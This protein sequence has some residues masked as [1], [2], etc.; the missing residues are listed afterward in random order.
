M[1]G[2]LAK[3]ALLRS[4]EVTLPAAATSL[5]FRGIFIMLMA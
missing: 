3:L 2:C 5:M 1:D 4:A